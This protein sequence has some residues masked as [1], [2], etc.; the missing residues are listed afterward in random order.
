MKLSDI[1]QVTPGYAFRGAIEETRNGNTLVFQARDLVQGVPVSDVSSL[2]KISLDLPPD[3][4]YLQKND[5]LIVARGMKAGAFRAAVFMSDAQNVIASASVHIIRIS[6]S[7]VLPEFLSHYLNSKEGQ[8]SLAN[9]VT[10]SY[11]GALP[12]RELIHIKIPVPELEKQKAIVALHENIQA[13][14]SIVDRRQYLKQQI[15]EATF[16]NLTKQHD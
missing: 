2:T 3:D 13:Q 8:D 11:I 6:T 9:I 12:R 16:T 7:K 15:V 10:G 1:A 5:V 4:R 14:Q